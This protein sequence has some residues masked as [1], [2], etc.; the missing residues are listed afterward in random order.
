MLDYK[1]VSYRGAGG[2]K[3]RW[4]IRKTMQIPDPKILIFQEKGLMF[5][6]PQSVVIIRGLLK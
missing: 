6:S 3:H 2:Y 4:N 5:C 1:I